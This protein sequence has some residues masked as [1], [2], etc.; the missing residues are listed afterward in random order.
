MK[1][2]TSNVSGTD[3]DGWPRVTRVVAHFDPVDVETGKSAK[4]PN[5]HD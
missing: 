1:P 2:G 4:I 3:K 5:I